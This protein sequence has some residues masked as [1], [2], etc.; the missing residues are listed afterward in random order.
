[1]AGDMQHFPIGVVQKDGD[2]Y[3]G[4]CDEVGTTSVGRTVDEAFA[5]LRLATWHALELQGAAAVA[6]D[7]VDMRVA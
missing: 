5:N 6:S 2:G 7:A 4:C 1:M 3:I